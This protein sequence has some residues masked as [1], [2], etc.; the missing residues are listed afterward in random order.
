MLARSPGFTIFVMAILTLGIGAT[1]AMLSVIDAVMLRS[2]AP[3]KDSE[4]LVC[5][6]ET[7]SYVHPVTHATGRHMSSV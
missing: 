3:Y 7:D 5:V 4:G 1:A 2:R 6:F